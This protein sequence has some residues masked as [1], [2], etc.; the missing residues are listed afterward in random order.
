MPTATEERLDQERR[1]WFTNIKKAEKLDRAYA[2]RTD[3]RLT[4]DERAAID[5]FWE[6]YRQAYPEIDY[7]SFESFKNR[8]G[9]FD[10][11]HIPS[12]VQSA[13]QTYFVQDGYDFAFRNK[14]MLSYLYPDAAHPRPL[15]MQ[16]NGF[17]FDG[18]YAL[19]DRAGAVAAICGYLKEKPQ[20]RVA[21]K[22]GVGLGPHLSTVLSAESGEAAVGAAI[23][24]LGANAFIAQEFVEQ[25]GFAA[26][27]NP[28]HVNTLC[29]TS[30]FFRGEYHLLA[31]LLRIGDEGQTEEL[32]SGHTLLGVDIETGLCNDWALTRDLR[33]VSQLGG[34]DLTAEKLQVP[35]FEAIKETVRRMHE[36]LPY[37]RLISF[38]MVLGKNDEPV[39]LECNFKGL[40]REHEAVTGPVYGA[41]TKRVLD[42]YLI[43]NFK[44]GLSDGSFVYKEDQGRLIAWRYIGTDG[45]AVVADS[46][47]GKSV[48]M[49]HPEA[50]RG[51]TPNRIDAPLRVLKESKAALGLD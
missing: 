12:G 10:A 43:Q 9:R 34:L 6:P 20:R 4:E 18:E 33:R 32:A 23:D 7:R 15:A 2:L 8:L 26:R 46:L 30:F 44:L 42:Y 14:A 39:L 1:A 29:V 38:E 17:L 21:I 13:L 48:A 31:A 36:K 5:R 16:M 22:P 11:R 47:N 50:F 49:I 35:N 24:R 40:V 19:T 3:E 37:A 51:Q 41:L 27:L 25:S 28:K 45:R